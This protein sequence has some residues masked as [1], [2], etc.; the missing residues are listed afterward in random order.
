MPSRKKAKPNP[1]SRK[2]QTP[3]SQPAAGTPSSQ[4]HRTQDSEQSN[5]THDEIAIKD[6]TSEAGLEAPG[7]A[8]NDTE[9]G[10]AIPGTPRS[11]RSWYGSWPRNSKAAPVA[12]VVNESMSATGETLAKAAA[13]TRAF[14]NSKKPPHRTSSSYLSP[15]ASARSLPVTATTTRLNIS[16]DGLEQA[17]ATKSSKST[18]EADKGPKESKDPDPPNSSAKSAKNVSVSTPEISNDNTS[19]QKSD[20]PQSSAKSTKSV[21]VSTNDSIKDVA[22]SLQAQESSQS[23]WMGW[24]ARN[25][26]KRKAQEDISDTN[27][28]PTLKTGD[29]AKDKGENAAEEPKESRKPESPSQRR[30]S[31]PAPQLPA[32]QRL[33]NEPQNRSSWLGMWSSGKAK[34][35]NTTSPL[36][37][38]ETKKKNPS[39]R[40]TESLPLPTSKEA[41]RAARKADKEELTL[42][43]KNVKQD[44]AEA[45][46]GSSWAFWSR[47]PDTTNKEV[48]GQLAVA[49]SSSQS[50]PEDAVVGTEGIPKAAAATA[51]TA[52]GKRGR[53]ATVEPKDAEEKKVKP[54]SKATVTDPSGN[55]AVGALA[56]DK[57]SEKRPSSRKDSTDN[58]L[59]PLF[60]QTYPS[61]PEGWTLLQQIGRLFYGRPPPARH[62]SLIKDPPRIKNALAIGV[63]GYFP[64]AIIQTVIGRPTGTSFK[65]M[66]SAAD[67]IHRFTHNQGY[68]PKSVE[69]IAL[70]GEGKIEERLDLLWKLLLNY[71][72]AIRQADFVLVACHSQGVPVAISLVA[73]LI[74]FG[75][76]NGAR[77]GICAMAGV[78]LGPFVDYKSRWIGGSAAELFEFA[79]SDSRVSKGYEEALDTAIRFGA[80][81]T[82]VGSLDDQLVS[83]HSST[84]GAAQ[85]PHIYRAVWI[86]GRLHVPDFLTHL[87]GFALKLRNLGVSDHG[88]IRELSNPLAGS[89]VGGEGHSRIYEDPAVYE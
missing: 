5:P 8:S 12:Q 13:K 81:V 24:F 56:A 7:G 38:S 73:K 62:P 32:I 10:S 28:G 40:S 72:D 80:K 86:D 59:L 66:E 20:P 33:A 63:H 43:Q 36:D 3:E 65:F 61:I 18:I 71:I 53:P 27:S 83:L 82:Y 58:L 69:K 60:K 17:E 75:C 68:E 55:F 41:E 2:S 29:E 79:R 23:Y 85:H 54:S 47:S 37:P 84:F 45:S 16:S 89:L 74:G 1:S 44:T 31:D 48:V 70:E 87:V 15:G 6:G 14:K 35:D 42:L 57:S 30:N 64:A 19:I 77:V 25:E 52:L 78:N 49:G 76:L 21:A 46:S 39:I 34:P 22:A 50:K 67:A 51:P 9:S 88:L 4:E 26:A 11:T